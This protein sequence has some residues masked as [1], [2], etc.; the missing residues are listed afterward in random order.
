MPFE[1]VQKA[2]ANPDCDSMNVTDVRYCTARSHASSEKMK[3][4]GEGR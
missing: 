2:L 4:M 1:R 3:R